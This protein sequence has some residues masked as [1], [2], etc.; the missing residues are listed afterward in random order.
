V[1][2]DHTTQL[3]FWNI[4]T[5]SHGAHAI[6]FGTRM[7]D[8]RDAN[9]TTSNFNGAFTFATYNQYLNMANG[10]AAGTP[11][12]TLVSQGYGPATASYTTSYTSGEDSSL[13]NVFDVALFAEDD[14]RV[15][16]RLT[17]SGGIR[18]ESQNH[19]ADHNDWAPRVGLAYALDGGKDRKNTKTV[20]RAGYGIFY[21][22]FGSGSLLTINRSNVLR[23]TVLNNP[24][25][26]GTATTLDAIDMT[27]CT[28]NGGTSTTTTPVKYEV[29]PAYSSPYTGQLGASIERQLLSGT[30]VTTTYLRSFGAHQ[31]VTRNANQATGGTPQTNAGGYLYEYY[32]EAVSKKTR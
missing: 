32:P 16:P 8:T 1:Y 31:M 10:L 11:F 22:R 26:T 9:L 21:D 27:T 17:L 29:S 24:T 30:S 5:M 13:A 28:S 12:N 23:Q 19:V 14:W 4:T 3:E 6:K 7:R 20:F 25:C 15:N 18:W 2:R